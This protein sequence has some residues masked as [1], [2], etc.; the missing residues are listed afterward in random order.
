MIRNKKEKKI[1]TT[2]YQYENQNLL[3]VT[4]Q[5]IKK[6]KTSPNIK[7][8]FQKRESGPSGGLMTTLDIYNKLTKKDL[9]NSLKIAGTG[10]IEEDGSIGEIGEIKYKL[11]GAEKQKADIFLAPTGENYETC[12]KVKKEKKLKIKIIE[13]KTIEDAITKLENLKEN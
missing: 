2:L 5:Q 1:K 3:G 11:L 7:I 6:Y 13:V 10:T 9:T 8:Q 4:L 12:K